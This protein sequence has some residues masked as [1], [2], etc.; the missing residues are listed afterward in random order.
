MINRCMKISK[1]DHN[2]PVH[3]SIILKVD[4]AEKSL[5]VRPV[6]KD[7]QTKKAIRNGNRRATA[8]S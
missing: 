7:L 6:E 4:L 5:H 3:I 8:C 1:N 2:D